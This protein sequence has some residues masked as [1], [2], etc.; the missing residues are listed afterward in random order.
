MAQVAEGGDGEAWF[1]DPPSQQIEV[2][3]ALGQEH[4]GGAGLVAEISADEGMGLVPPGDAFEV[5]DRADLA[6]DAGSDPF[7]DF[8]VIRG[9]LEAMADAEHDAIV[10][11]GVDDGPAVLRGRGHGFFQQEV[12][13]FFRG[14]N[15]GSHM[16]SIGG[17]DDEGI[18]EPGPGQQIFPIGED[19]V[20]G[21]V[22]LAGGLVALIFTGFGHGH[23]LGVLIFVQDGRSEAVESSTAGTDQGE[24]YFFVHPFNL[25]FKIT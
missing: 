9:I 6:E 20:L 5:L 1:S 15:G 16:Q 22:V 25:S 18:G 10:P 21:D 4:E 14:S 24:C 7:L 3:T 19:L 2:V 13:A 12:V 11:A 8:F 23:D 17:C